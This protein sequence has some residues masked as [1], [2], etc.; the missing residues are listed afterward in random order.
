LPH[1]YLVLKDPDEWEGADDGSTQNDHALRLPFHSRKCQ[2][3]LPPSKGKVSAPFLWGSKKHLDCQRPNRYNDGSV[4]SRLA[5]ALAEARAQ[6]CI[7]LSFSDVLAACSA[8]VA[9]GDSAAMEVMSST[10]HRVMCHMPVVLPVY[11]KLGRRK[12]PD[13][14]TMTSQCLYYQQF[15]L[16]NTPCNDK[17]FVRSVLQEGVLPNPLGLVL[18]RRAGALEAVPETRWYTQA[19]AQQTGNVIVVKR[20]A[21]AIGNPLCVFARCTLDNRGECG[22]AVRHC[23]HPTRFD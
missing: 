16:E 14:P 10:L 21:A 5:A 18:K 15:V 1:R 2:L 19:T 23:Y 13:Q 20:R 11:E 22:W 17:T 9:V 6:G 3:S 4:V 12:L 8:A 7:T